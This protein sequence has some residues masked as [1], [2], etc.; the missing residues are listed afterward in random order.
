MPKEE[1]AGLIPGMRWMASAS[2]DD[3]RKEKK[4]RRNRPAGVGAEVQ[5]LMRFE[6]RN[7]KVACVRCNKYGSRKEPVFSSLKRTKRARQPAC[8][9]VDE[10][11]KDKGWARQI[12]QMQTERVQKADGFGGGLARFVREWFRS[13]V[14]GG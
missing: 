12:V 7:G 11:E 6:L 3:A 14:D 5:K 2:M 8:L 4:A 10:R 13:A 1:A 9:L